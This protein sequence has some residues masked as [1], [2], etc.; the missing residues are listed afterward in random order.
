M[1]WPIDKLDTLQ[2]PNCA[3][4]LQV[5]LQ[6]HSYRWKHS[7]TDPCIHIVKAY[8][9]LMTAQSLS[10]NSCCHQNVCGIWCNNNAELL[11][12][13]LLICVDEFHE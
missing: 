6:P 10:L 12:S 11:A 1:T 13:V 2:N 9:S 7:T 3:T 4:L 5:R 8:P